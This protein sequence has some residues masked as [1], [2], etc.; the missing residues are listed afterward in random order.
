MRKENRSFPLQST[1]SSITRHNKKLRSLDL[2]FFTPVYLSVAS[3]A[4]A[5]AA[6]LAVLVAVVAAARAAG[7]ATAAAAAL[8][9]QEG[10]LAAHKKLCCIVG[11]AAEAGKRDNAVGRQRRSCVD[12]DVADDDCVD[13]QAVHKIGDRLMAGF[14][15]LDKL[16][17]EDLGIVVIRL[18]DGEH[19]GMAEVLEYL[20]VLVRNCDYHEIGRAHV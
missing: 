3:A 14:L 5:A 13:V 20:I 10:E 17:G 1:V 4:A 19:L 9:G 18:V 15:D 6:V 8:V 12:T 16:L 2:S 11:I 7:A